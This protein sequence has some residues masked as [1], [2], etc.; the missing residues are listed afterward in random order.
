[1]S[2]HWAAVGLTRWG[3]RGSAISGAMEAKGGG[4]GRPQASTFS[5]L[6]MEKVACTI[7]FGIEHV[8]A[9]G[10]RG[11]EST[12]WFHKN[13]RHAVGKCPIQQLAQEPP[14]PPQDGVPTA[15][16]LAHAGTVHFSLVF[17]TFGFSYCYHPVLCKLFK[18]KKK[19][20]KKS[21]LVYCPGSLEISS[22]ESLEDEFYFK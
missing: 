19:K 1:M 4:Q 17:L 8:N 7:I 15:G 11:R 5:W 21:G 18:E 3:S 12:F 10:Q 2:V 6:M 13:Y 14:T 9:R 20:S 16:C 22:E